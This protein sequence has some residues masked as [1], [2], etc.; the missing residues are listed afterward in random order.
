MKKNTRTYQVKSPIVLVVF[1][2]F[3]VTQKVFDIIKEVKPK[4]LFV[5][6]DGW[7]ENVKDEKEKCE[8]TREIIDQ[9]DWE[10]KVYKKFSDVNLGGPKN[11]PQGLNWVFDKVEKAIIL[12]DD[13]LADLSFFKFCDELLE[14]YQNNSQI[15][16]IAGSNAEIIDNVENSY[17]FARGTRVWGWA[18]WKRAWK[19]FDFDM[20]KWPQIKQNDDLAKRFYTKN[21]YKI[22]SKKA[23]DMYQKKIKNWDYLWQFACLSNNGYAIVPN[24]TL[25]EH[26]GYGE[27]AQHTKVKPLFSSV[28]KVVPMHFPL[29]HPTEIVASK[30]FEIKT[31]K[32]KHGF[33]QRIKYIIGGL[34]NKFSK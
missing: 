6:A 23:E 21:T 12:E 13:I 2:R 24:Q 29:I 5:V 25:I 19:H 30:R 31:Y 14:K 15:M 1:K 26:I 7:R 8:K 22:Q 34:L 28:P 32:R 10:C 18:T 9:V 20:K 3:E 16:H 33:K 17:F 27:D 4:Q 11:F